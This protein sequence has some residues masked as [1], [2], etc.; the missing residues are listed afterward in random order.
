MEFVASG[1]VE[2]GSWGLEARKIASP[3]IVIP[4]ARRAV[5]DPSPALFF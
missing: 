1:Q 5:R 2:K 3:F 4:E